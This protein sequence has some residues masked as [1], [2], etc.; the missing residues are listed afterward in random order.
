MTGKQGPKS[1]RELSLA[2]SRKP[3]SRPILIAY[4]DVR[5]LT[6]A[7]SPGDFES[8]LGFG[9]RGQGQDGLHGPESDSSP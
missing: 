5:D 6:L 1:V 9:R 7:P 4:G 8:G 3:Y 2:S